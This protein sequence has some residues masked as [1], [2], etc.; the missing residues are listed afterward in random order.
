MAGDVLVMIWHADRASS[1]A[2]TWVNGMLTS[3]ILWASVMVP[4]GTTPLKKMVKSVGIE[5]PTSRDMSMTWKGP[6]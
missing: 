3:V 6:G 4:R 1:V 2:D 5:P